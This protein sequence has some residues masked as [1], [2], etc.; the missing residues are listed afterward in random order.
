MADYELFKQVYSILENKQYLTLDNFTKMDSIKASI[1]K[2]GLSDGLTEAFPNIIPFKKSLVRDIKIPD[3]N[4][5]AGFTSREGYFLINL[6]KSNTHKW[7][8]RV[9]LSFIITQHIIDEQ[10]IRSFIPYL[11]CINVYKDK[12]RIDYWVVKYVDITEKIIP[13]FQ[14]YPIKGIKSY[15]FEDFCKTAE[16]MKN[17]AHFTEK[18]LEEIQNIKANMNRGRTKM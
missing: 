5:L 8:K 6:T 7:N 12:D 11:D 3:P 13:F 1:D 9:N 14:K 2:G 18:G 10:L 15:H 17:K 4:W 16:L